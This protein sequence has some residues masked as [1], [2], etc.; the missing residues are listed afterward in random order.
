M[1]YRIYNHSST[2]PSLVET[3][4][5]PKLASRA[6]MILSAQEI[7]NGRVANFRVEPP[8]FY[9]ADELDLPTWVVETLGL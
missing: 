9:R 3:W 6:V 4:N 8:T 5:H 2:P 1:A 7:R